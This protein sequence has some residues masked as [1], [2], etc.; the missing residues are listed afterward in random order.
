M[1]HLTYLK[2]EEYSPSYIINLDSLNNVILDLICH[3]I[4]IDLPIEQWI[5]KNCYYVINGHMCCDFDTKIAHNLT[6]AQQHND[7]QYVTYISNKLK[8]NIDENTWEYIPNKIKLKFKPCFY[9]GFKMTQQLSF[10]LGLSCDKIFKYKT[11]ILKLI[12]KYIYDHKLQDM[13]DRKTIIPDDKLRGI[14]STDNIQYTY[15]NLMT[16]INTHII[17]V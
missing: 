5:Q 6:L 1:N 3:D 15:F 8:I 11:D 9:K 4:G 14:L 13:N 10:V 16:H 12:H 17:P 2:Y 7:K